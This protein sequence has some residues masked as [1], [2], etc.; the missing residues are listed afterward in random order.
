MQVESDDFQT[1]ER[2]PMRKILTAIIIAF[3]A[4]A[5]AASNPAAEKAIKSVVAQIDTCINNRDAKCLGELFAEDGT[6]G[7]PV[8]HGKIANGR[9]A[10]VRLYGDMLKQPVPEGMKQVRSV[11]RIRF[12]G[13]DRALVDSSVKLTGVETA[14]GQD[15]H[16][17]MLMRSQDGKWL[18]EDVRFYVVVTGAPP[19]PGP[20]PAPTKSADADESEKPADPAAPAGEPG[21]K[22]EPGEPAPPSMG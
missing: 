3:A 15:W 16:T 18:L 10:I 14:A 22:D 13:D 21:K 2:K 11:E 19:T 17:V 5:L 8:E 9:A 6:F 12:L 20:T 1:L 7:G 4:P